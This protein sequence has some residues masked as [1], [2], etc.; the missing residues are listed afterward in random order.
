[1][2]HQFLT[3]TKHAFY[4]G[5]TFL[6][7]TESFENSSEIARFRKHQKISVLRYIYCLKK[8][9]LYQS[10]Q[11]IFNLIMKI[12]AQGAMWM[13]SSEAISKSVSIFFRYFDT[14]NIFL[15]D[16]NE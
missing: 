8:Y 16:N 7:R 10:I 9:V 5:W 13:L 14:I 3:V 6:N 12:E 4:V 15:D 1:M 11:N 2:V